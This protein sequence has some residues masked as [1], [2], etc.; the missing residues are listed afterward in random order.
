ML[1][2]CNCQLPISKSLTQCLSV[3]DCWLTRVMTQ[4]STISYTGLEYSPQAWNLMSGVRIQDCPQHPQVPPS[5][6]KLTKTCTSQCMVM[7]WLDAVRILIHWS[8][9]ANKPFQCSIWEIKWAC[10]E[11]LT[12]LVS[13]SVMLSFPISCDNQLHPVW[14]DSSPYVFVSGDVKANLAVGE[15][16]NHWVIIIISCDNRI[17]FATI[18]SQT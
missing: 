16:T 4:I 3:K 5:P 7:P 8:R 2:L 14:K 18:N 12:P 6:K 11:P 17:T 1:L 10:I 13:I 15:S 9:K